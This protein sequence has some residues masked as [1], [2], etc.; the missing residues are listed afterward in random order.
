MDA[1]VA[2]RSGLL[3]HEDLIEDRELTDANEDR[4]E[5]QR[6]A[7]QLVELAT[8]V[9]APTNI[10]LYGPWGSG[11]SGIA[12]LVKG[13][14]QQV[15]G[16]RF[17]RFDA[18]KYAENP[19][20]RNFV[21]AAAKELG[22]T[23]AKYHEDLYSGRTRTDIRVPATSIRKLVEVF[24][25]LLVVM[26]ALIVGAIAVIALFQAGP[27]GENFAKMSG[28]AVTAG[29][30]PATLLSGLIALVGKN[31]AAE[32]SLS[33]PDSD[34]Q[35]E[36]LL[37]D[38]VKDSKADRVVIFVDELDRCSSE[39]V[40]AT[41]DAVRTFL[42]TN[43][44]VFIVAADQQVLEEALSRK[45]QQPTPVTAHN[46]Y[47]STGSAYLDKVFQYQISLPALLAPNIGEFALNLVQ[48]R[49]SGVWKELT[50]LPLVISVLIP[51][52][53]TS[54][55]R[56]KHLLNTFAL[57]YRLAED[58]HRTGH[59]HENPVQSATALA[60]LVCL[61]VEFPLFGR[62]LIIDP[63]LPSHVLELQDSRS[64]PENLAPDVKE[65]AQGYNKPEAKLAPLMVGEGDENGEGVDGAGD[66]RVT[67]TR[68]THHRQLLN[69]LRRT[70]TVEGPS[71]DL[72]FLRSEESLFGLE[73]AS[74]KRLVASAEDGDTKAV[75]D[76][77]G[78]EDV[79]QDQ[80][81][82]ALRY[83]TTRMRHS[84]GVAEQNIASV[85]VDLVKQRPDLSYQIV[86]DE[87]LAS[88]SNLAQSGTD[89][90]TASNASG[91]WHLALCATGDTDRLR[92]RII[93]IAR[94]DK[95]ADAQFI[96]QEPRA[97]AADGAG[98]SALLVR[99]LCSPD[100]ETTLATLRALDAS[101][102][103][104]LLRL[105]RTLPSLLAEALNTPPDTEPAQPATAAAPATTASTATAV[106]QP[107]ESKQATVAKQAIESLAV[108]AHDLRSDDPNS[109][110]AIVELV[111]AID[112]Q[113]GRTQIDKIISD[114]PPTSDSDLAGQILRSVELRSVK[115]WPRWLAAITPGCRVTDADQL[116][117]RLVTTLWNSATSKQSP[118]VADVERAAS[119]LL[120][121]IEPLPQARPDITDEV[122][123]TV[124][125][126]VETNSDAASRQPAVIAAH[127]LAAHGFVDA[128]LLTTT[129]MDSLTKTLRADIAEDD[130][131]DALRLYL[132]ETVPE[133]FKNEVERD[134]A[135]TPAIDLMT[136]LTE[137]H[138][139][140]RF[141]RVHLLLRS[142][143][144]A[145]QHLPAFSLLLPT[146]DTMTTLADELVDR[147]AEPL[148]SW[149]RLAMVTPADARALLSTAAGTPLLTPDV[150]A[151]FKQITAG[152]ND[153]EHL[154]FVRA[155][156]GKPESSIPDTKIITAID[157]TG[158]NEGGVVETLVERYNASTNNSMRIAVLNLWAAASIRK[159]PERV[160]L[161]KQVAIVM[162][163][164][165]SNG[166]PNAEAIKAVF[167]VMPQ[168]GPPPRKVRSAFNTAAQRAVD[169]KKDLENAALQGLKPLGYAT[170][171]AGRFTARQVI[172][173]TK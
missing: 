100:R 123:K 137:E 61:R 72:V 87:V 147:S 93:Q 34:E 168:I 28:T 96:L 114:L 14:L 69:Y 162:L 54:P 97:A 119:A 21:T 74:A 150:V 1:D 15:K 108:L 37:A 152:W 25:I 5:H 33:K 92:R 103:L 91:A 159:D 95:D 62:D 110:Y 78:A 113:Y 13:K 70:R 136:A 31:L 83:L 88:I 41:L 64:L 146:A 17:I 57:T 58:R 133:V 39:D 142:L 46:P 111:L 127:V 7:D 132:F 79:P 56:V 8:S 148:A 60:K 12:N 149:L 166:S 141:G 170:K 67:D 29:L 35:F 112:N 9:E 55:R 109:A 40:V 94:D 53:V 10:A 32:R 38:L 121:Q 160:E 20:R 22:V 77:V 126:T 164:L 151:A 167:R 75:V 154:E 84:F 169:G 165:R 36:A 68:H 131:G 156:V 135:T 145:G 43:Q 122:V 59:L 42:G 105:V 172:D 107:V 153:E 24:A 26:V 144:H 138:W 3:G 19:L 66:K 73:T 98:T 140:T 155:F 27:F 157:L 117:A 86:A 51:S 16:V 71:R 6:I 48:T 143:D 45:S 30:V 49:E 120:T 76:T 163:E 80:C 128:T 130:R 63:D 116:W 2:V 50:N 82:A 99:G 118:G 101:A 89:I 65:L 18:F 106:P 125:E 4:F 139:M 102:R 115:A 173:F 90:L 104:E 11:K 44:C 47:Y 134:G 158:A 85:L 81:D 124:G 52:H 23:D 171:L 161:F 129:L